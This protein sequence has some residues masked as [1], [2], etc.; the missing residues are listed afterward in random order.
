MGPNKS[1]AIVLA[2][3]AAFYAAPVFAGSITLNATLR[4]FCSSGAAG[5]AGCSN[6]PDFPNG[7]TGSVSG[8][9]NSTL[10]GDGKP[11]YN[12]PSSGVFTN[13][14][15]FNQWYNSAPA[16]NKTIATTLTLAE[17][18]SG[19]GVYQYQNGA[20]FPLDGQ[21]WGNQ[22]LAHNY[23]FTL[24]THTTFT[25]QA[26]Q[27]FNFTGDDDVWVFINGQLVVDLGGIHAAQSAA[28]NLDSLGL[29]AGN[30]YDFDFFFAERHTTDSN[31]RIQT[32]IV[33]NP[34]PDPT[35]P[36]PATLALLGAALAGLGLARRRKTQAT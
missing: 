3:L 14:A 32:S 22:G 35:V 11:V 8:A 34:N 16:F 10:G 31:L 7:A 15:N 21:G 25:Y 26:G 19:S 5:V 24:E 13:A 1:F 28:V 2:S 29:T 6:H 9:V 23:H 12:A 20:Y 36:E 17:T 30:D 33:F 27:T 18:A 4:D